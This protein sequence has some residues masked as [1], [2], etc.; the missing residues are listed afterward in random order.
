M[1]PTG[2]P[3]ASPGS[4]V[5]R[6]PRYLLHKPTNR[7][8]ARFDGASSTYYGSYNRAASLQGY[9]RCVAERIQN[10]GRLAMA[11]QSASVTDGVVAYTEFCKRYYRK[12][13]K[14]TDELRLIKVAAKIVRELYGRSRATDIG[15]SR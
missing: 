3:T 12:G 1:S 13:D 4:L 10:G 15:P 5:E 11:T 6:I 14:P 7:G 8:Y 9:N 2:V